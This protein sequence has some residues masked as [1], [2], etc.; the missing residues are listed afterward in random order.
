MLQLALKMTSKTLLQQQGC[1][2]TDL[3]TY[4]FTNTSLRGKI[5][6]LFSKHYSP[7]HL[8]VSSC[9]DVCSLGAE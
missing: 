3:F 9:C 8:Q 6:A 5:A 4:L 2:N 7:T 1:I